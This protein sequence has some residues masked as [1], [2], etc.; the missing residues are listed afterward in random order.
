[1]TLKNIGVDVRYAT[2]AK[3]GRLIASSVDI[4]NS[5][6]DLRLRDGDR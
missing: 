6:L 5:T 3:K 1:M 4:V 2:K